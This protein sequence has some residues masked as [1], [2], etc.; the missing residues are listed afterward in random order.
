MLL[1]PLSLL[2]A[3]TS[4]L[5]ASQ[6]AFDFVCLFLAGGAFVIVF[7]RVV[8]SLLHWLLICF[9]TPLSG[10]ILLFVSVRMWRM[11][12]KQSDSTIKPPIA[13]QIEH[14]TLPILADDTLGSR[15]DIRLLIANV[16]FDL[17]LVRFFISDGKIVCT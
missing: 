5:L 7:V 1:A 9:W 10:T 6:F 11:I 3:S 8:H 14:A 15:R 13:M 16:V 2:L 17:S 12:R 4:L